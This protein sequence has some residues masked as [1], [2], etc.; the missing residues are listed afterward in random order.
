MVA[1]TFLQI[2]EPHIMLLPLIPSS[3]QHNLTS[4]IPT[5]E[6]VHLFDIVTSNVTKQLGQS[7]GVFESRVNQLLEK[8]KG[9]VVMNDIC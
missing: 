3:F 1:G 2:V 7:H 5:L 4:P 6:K 9:E 8:E